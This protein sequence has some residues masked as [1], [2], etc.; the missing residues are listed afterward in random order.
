MGFACN[1][2][3]VNNRTAKSNGVKSCFSSADRIRKDP[4][5]R[6]RETSLE[7]S[8]FRGKTLLGGRMGRGNVV[9]TTNDSKSAGRKQEPGH[10]VS[11][12]F[13]FLEPVTLTYE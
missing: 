10:P 9:L 7:R 4:L 5:D 11:L 2:I 8:S 1:L 13:N 3:E 12:S 6:L